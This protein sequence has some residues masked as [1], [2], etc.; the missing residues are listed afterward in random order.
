[1]QYPSDMDEISG[2]L[3]RPAVGEIP[4]QPGVYR[5]FGQDDRVLY[6]GKAKNLRARLSNYFGPPSSM[7]ERTN[8]MVSSA[9]R[10]DW[11]VVGSEIEALQLEYSWIKAYAPPFNVVFRDDKSYPYIAL[12]LADEAPRA[13]ITRNSKIRGA[14]YF[15]P[16]PKVWSVYETLALLQQAIPIRTCKNSDYD[17]AMK[18]GRPCFASQINKCAG[19]CSQ[20]VSFEEHRKQVNDYMA[21]LNGKTRSVV[22]RMTKKMFTASEAHDFERA[23]TLRDQI[24]SLQEL[25]QNNAIVLDR[26]TNVDV[27][28]V[29]YDDLSIAAELFEVREGRIISA[30]NWSGALE[31]D[32]EPEVALRKLIFEHYSTDRTPAR[33]VLV[34]FLP[35]DVAEIESWLSE[36]SGR[37]VR[38]KTVQRGKKKYLLETVQENARQDLARYKLKRAADYLARTKAMTE[39]QHALGMEQAPLRIECYDVSH[40]SG[41]DVV[42]SMVVFEDGVPKKRDYRSFNIVGTTDDTASMHQMLTRRLQRLNDAEQD[43]QTSFAYFPQLIL[44][45]GGIP[46]VNAAKKALDE[47]GLSHRIMLAGLAK[48]LEELWIPGEDFP[49]VLPR[50]SDGLFLLQ[51]V[52]DEAH[53][54]AISHQKKKR[55]SH[56]NSVLAEIPGVG[57]ARQQ[58]LLKRFGS[59]K[60]IRESRPQDLATTPGISAAL[61]DVIFDH[62]NRV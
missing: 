45:D 21:V 22:K 52:R 40:L 55:K 14:K 34:P 23:A 42:G 37:V 44:V 15:G 50:N 29:A 53:R 49:L 59:V 62:L 57:P 4:T 10:V 32:T 27:F 5:F 26:E 60:R 24:A 28:G 6:V 48:R 33:E 54:F 38:L 58:A 31:L 61:A 25:V 46:Q 1:M 30:Q 3:V 17:R 16:F 36:I 41:S 39:V 11:T 13:L 19:P 2:K 47:V 7:M 43:A 35:E 51:R 8:L 12:T 18:T 56:I 9:L 20:K